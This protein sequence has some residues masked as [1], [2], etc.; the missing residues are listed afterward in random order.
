MYYDRF[1]NTVDYS[2][3]CYPCCVANMSESQRYTLAHR[4]ARIDYPCCGQYEVNIPLPF[5][6]PN[7][8]CCVQQIRCGG[9]W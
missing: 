1:G 8:P 4:Q 5:I 9:R 6:N 7:V 3:A 2:V